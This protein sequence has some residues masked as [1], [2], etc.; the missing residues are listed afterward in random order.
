MGKP[1]PEIDKAGQAENR[2][3]AN[4]KFGGGNGTTGDGN[5]TFEDSVR[6]HAETT[7]KNALASYHKKRGKKAGSKGS[8]KRLGQQQRDKLKEKS[9]QRQHQKKLLA[10]RGR[11]APEEARAAKRKVHEERLKPE[12]RKAQ[13]DALTA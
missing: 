7:N 2:A 11:R 8:A 13:H 5:K 10:S 4:R 9:V 3:K 1:K 12:E 6:E